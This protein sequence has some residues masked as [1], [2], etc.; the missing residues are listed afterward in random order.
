MRINKKILELG[1]IKYSLQ[2]E[3]E[4]APLLFD[5]STD[6]ERSIMNPSIINI[7]GNLLVNCRVVNYMLWHMPNDYPVDGGPLQ[8]LHP[9]QDR[10][11]TTYNYI[12]PLNPISL[13]LGEVTKIDM[14][15]DVEP[16]WIFIGLEDGRLLQWGDHTY[17][18]GVRRDTDDQGTG[19]IELTELEGSIGAVREVARIRIPLPVGEESYCEKNWVPIADQPY[20]FLRWLN[21]VVILEYDPVNNYS[22]ERKT[23]Q[24]DLNGLQLRGSTQLIPYEDKYICLAHSVQLW[25]PIFGEKEGN[26]DTHLCVFDKKLNLEYVSPAFKFN[27][28]SKVEFNCGMAILKDHLYITFSEEDNVAHI[29]KLRKELLFE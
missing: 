23:N 22:V 7:D 24:L 4:I 10:T 20:K 17:L 8:Y 3:G 9:E 26:Y 28:N 29:L 6:K 18:M 1:L 5:I 15:L 11:L 27:P 25:K 16:K 21:P 13:E 14:K 2:N 12:A 19:R